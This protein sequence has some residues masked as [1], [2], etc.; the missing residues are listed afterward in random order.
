[1]FTRRS[2]QFTQVAR[3][4]G[5]LVHT[6]NNQLPQDLEKLST[7]GFD[8]HIHTAHH[9]DSNLDHKTLTADLPANLLLRPMRVHSNNKRCPHPANSDGFCRL[10]YSARMIMVQQSSWFGVLPESDP[11]PLA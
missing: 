9:G 8:F 6:G 7:Q 1:M 4:D 3:L 11:E 5:I 10:S 2:L